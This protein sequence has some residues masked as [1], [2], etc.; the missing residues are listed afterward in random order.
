MLEGCK[1]HMMDGDL[2]QTFQN[3]WALFTPSFLN[4]ACASCVADLQDLM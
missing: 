2:V 1:A 4:V 3:T